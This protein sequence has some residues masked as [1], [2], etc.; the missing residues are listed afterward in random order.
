MP[1]VETRGSENNKESE[2]N[3]EVINFLFSRCSVMRYSTTTCKSLDII[4]TLH[5]PDWQIAN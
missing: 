4:P 1:R 5:E 2:Q 3:Q